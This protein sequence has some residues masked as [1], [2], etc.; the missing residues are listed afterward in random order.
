MSKRQSED[1][2]KADATFIVVDGQCVEDFWRNGLFEQV[3]R[4]SFSV[5]VSD[6]VW[7]GALNSLPISARA[8][9]LSLGLKVVVSPGE[10]TQM[11]AWHKRN[12]PLLH[13]DECY[14]LVIAQC[15]PN[16]VLVAADPQLRAA[17]ENVL[18]S[19][20]K[21]SAWLVQFLG[22]TPPAPGKRRK[23]N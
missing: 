9:F 14:S 19:R 6:M 3:L 5:A 8:N 15:F 12:H 17:A 22:E 1:Q 16:A 4:T 2:Y 7:D 18:N 13:A 10:H 20:L 11:V 23:A 21:T